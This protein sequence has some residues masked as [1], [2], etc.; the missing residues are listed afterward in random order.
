MSPRKRYANRINSR[1]STGPRTREGKAR[2]ARNARRHGLRALRLPDSDAA[3][4]VGAL[5]RAIAG[6]NAA[7]QL[8]ARAW[9]V[10]RAQVALRRVSA[11]RHAILL[12][13][14]REGAA[15]FA[16]IAAIERYE[17]KARKH[18]KIAIAAFEAARRDVGVCEEQLKRA[19]FLP[20]KANG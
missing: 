4:E 13:P 16:A 11:A 8:I 9:R 6:T 3:S 18:R 7:A 15:A 1:R 12:D 2:V 5:A 20:N 17:T 10:A 14:S 19:T